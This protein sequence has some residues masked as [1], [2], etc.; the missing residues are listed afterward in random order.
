MV[1]YITLHCRV[2]RDLQFLAPT[3]FGVCW[4]MHRTFAEAI[5]VVKGLFG[6]NVSY[7]IWVAAAQWIVAITQL[8]ILVSRVG[9][10]LLSA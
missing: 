6:C 5:T 8:L 3:L 9:V 4:V 7:E 2:V 1:D 10:C